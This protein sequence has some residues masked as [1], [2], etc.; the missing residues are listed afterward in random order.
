MKLR[1]F[2]AVAAVAVVLSAPV[3]AQQAANADPKAV[4]AGT[5][6]VET[7][8][9]RVLFSLNHFGFNDYY[10]EFVGAT[11]SLVI[12]PK[13]PAASKLD[14]S[15]PTAGISTTNAKLD[16]ELKAADW[17]DAAQFP[18]IRFVSTSVK[19]TGANTA[20]VAG[21]LT[22][23]GVTK[24]VVLDATFNAAGP[25]PFSKAFTTGFHVQGK[26]KR[27]DFGV[28][29]YVPLVGDEVNLVISAA[30]EKKA[31]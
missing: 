14:V 10:G 25:N 17:F 29:K 24:P 3:I 21:N 7:S 31:G 16:E 15:V 28:N 23:H 27:S 6:A 13:N 1:I 11:G 18:T 9:T 20:K 19:Q 5:Y 22:L 2:S 26:I 8:H 4:E 12:D 30:F